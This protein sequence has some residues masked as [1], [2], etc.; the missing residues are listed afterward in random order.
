MAGGPSETMGGAGGGGDVPAISFSDVYP[1]LTANCSGMTCHGDGASNGHPEFASMTEAT[2]EAAATEHAME[3]LD[4]VTRMPGDMG[5]MP[6]MGQNALGE[7]D[8]ST[9][10]AWVESL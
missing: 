2:A 10:Q 9:I 6:F 3:L 1:I 4:R 5:F 7:E 8:I